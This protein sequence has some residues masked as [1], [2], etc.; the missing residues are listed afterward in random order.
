MA[1]VS[2]A[3]GMHLTPT[4]VMQATTNNYVSSL[5]ATSG[6]LHKRDV[7]EKLIKRYGDQG[8]TGLL[9]LMGSKA[10]VAN[11]N[12]EHYEEAFRHNDMT[13][14]V[15]SDGEAGASADGTGAIDVAI[16]DNHDTG[17]FN[18]D[19]PVRV[20]D[21]VLFADGDMG[22]VTVRTASP[23]IDP[24]TIMPLTTWGSD[25]TASATY[26]MTIIGNA[27]PEKSGQ[28]ESIIPL[29]HEYENNVMILKESF[30]VSGSEAT[31]VVYVK[32][33]NEKMG[34]G[35]LWYLKGEA[36][37]YKRFLDYCELQLI[38]GKKM[39][40]T[41]TLVNSSVSATIDGTAQSLETLRGTEGLFSFVENKGQSMDLGSA[42]IT[43][44]DFDAMVKS[45]DKYRG[46]KE[47]AMYCGINLSLD[48]DDL[49]AAQGAYAAG[50]ANYGTFQNSKDMAL[51]LGFNSFSRG[52]YT[53]HKKTY[54]LLNHPKLT[55]MTG[56]N[57]PG[58]GICIPMDMQKDA[59]SGN[60]IPSLRMRYK[61]A[62]GYSREMEHWLTGSAI[63]QNKTETQDRLK[64]HYR[65]ERGFEGFAANRYMLI[66]KS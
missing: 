32:V 10:P 1:T 38:L 50:G 61:A 64:S 28:P 33:D 30:E 24:I 21:I 54:D 63:L 44:A 26:E 60:K 37:T 31:N 23:A 39:T 53:F 45:L 41:T 27:Y 15:Q 29:L 57:Y 43:M 66:K 8:I 58:W 51:N 19:H 9:E 16:T 20:G 34:S 22:Y 55:A 46:A 12:F 65:T 36:D 7:S 56:S 5:T 49:L 17:D 62:N 35:Y 42:S 11:T 25:K 59:K 2:L 13:V 4:S 47:Y 3:S 18:N 48:I 14:T 6:E 52:G 40:N